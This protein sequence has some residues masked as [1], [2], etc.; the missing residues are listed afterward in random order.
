MPSDE[1]DLITFY[2]KL[3]TLVHSISK[4]NVLIIG[5]DMNAQITKDENNKFC[6]HNLSN[7]N[8]EYLTYFS[9]KNRLTCLN[10]KFLK[11]EGKLW[12][13]TYP[14]NAKAQIYILINQKWINRALNY[15]VYSSFQG[16]S[17][18]HRTVTAKI[19]WS[20]YRKKNQT[21][22]TTHYDLSSLNKR[23]ISNK[24]KP[25]AKCKVPW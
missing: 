21:D 10:T 22:R 18:D 15:E 2:N 7:K 14:N 11:R 5:G 17:S 9:L 13:Y 8:G 25:R 12:T 6:L 3:S 23:D 19:C 24:Y 16:V 1:M 4:H 20:Q